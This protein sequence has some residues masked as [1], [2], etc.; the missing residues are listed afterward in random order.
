MNARKKGGKSCISCNMGKKKDFKSWERSQPADAPTLEDRTDHHGNRYPT[1]PNRSHCPQYP[2]AYHPTS[3]PVKCQSHLARDGSA[4]TAA[5]PRYDRAA[6]CPCPTAWT[7][8]L[9]AADR[10]YHRADH[11]LVS[12]GFCALFVHDAGA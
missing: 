1:D 8:V 12:P 2:R 10:E 4:G 5:T 7:R 11:R 9:H 3:A 6:S